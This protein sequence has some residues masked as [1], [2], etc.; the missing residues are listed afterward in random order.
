MFRI[1]EKLQ[2]QLQQLL[3]HRYYP[4]LCALLLAFLPRTA[5]LSVV[6]VA[7]VTLR[8]GW[9]DGAFL[10]VPVAT[11]YFSFSLISMSFVGS[12]INMLVLFVPCYIAAGVL[13]VTVTWQAV[14]SVFFLLISF[15]SILTQLF[16]PDFIITQYLYLENFL[17]ETQT[18][19]S[20]TKLLSEAANINQAVIAS[21]AFGLQILSISL[22]A[23]LA[24]MTARA[25]QS[26]LYNAGGFKNE[27]LSFR[28]NK[29]GLIV[30]LFLFIAVI[31]QNLIAMML[32]PAVVIYFLLVGLSV[33]ANFLDKRNGRLLFLLFIPLILVPF[34]TVP[35]YST[36]GLFNSLFNL[37]LYLL[38]P[39]KRG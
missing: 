2:K 8:K 33:S 39:K 21:Y 24:L 31:Q 17:K 5:W 6:I 29:V 20:I 28:A 15:V 23:I 12:L 3:E 19:A 10:L 9:R 35:F 27:M 11:A 7:F 37:R 26:R 14:V 34:V 16:A 25:I 32:L 1:G 13:R 38:R 4:F 22:S 18:D 30:L 36:L